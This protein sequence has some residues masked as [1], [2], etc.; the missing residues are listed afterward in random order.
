MRKQ[1]K[2]ILDRLRARTSDVRRQRTAARGGL[3]EPQRIT[4]HGRS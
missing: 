3:Q 1:L 4:G 2:R